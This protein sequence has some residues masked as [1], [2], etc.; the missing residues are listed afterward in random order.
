MKSIFFK[1]VNTFFLKFFS[2][3]DFLKKIESAKINRAS[4]QVI[5]G[6]DSAFYPESLVQNLKNDI[7]CITI[8]NNT[9][10]RGE[11]CIYAY[12][13]QLK[14]GNNCYIGPNSVIRAGESIVI[15]DNVLIA[16]NVTIIDSD[17]HEIDSVERSES[18]K[19]MI[20]EGH[21]KEKGN[22]RT[23]PIIIHDN[24]W[25]SYNVSVL[26]GITIGEGAIIAAGSVVTK[27]VPDRTL[28]AGNPAVIIKK[29]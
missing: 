8:G 4:K 20:K 28:V 21:P 5:L 11:L 16:H 22:V 9:H 10:I 6:N 1:I 24:V 7:Y 15:G 26:K 27:D 12:A 29:I 25:L 14:I 2:D 3:E 18:Y 23:K 17:S 19:K 13:K